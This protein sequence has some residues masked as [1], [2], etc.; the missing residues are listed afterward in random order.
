MI[1]RLLINYFYKTRLIGFKE[2]K[3]INKS[4]RLIDYKKIYHA[5]LSVSK[6]TLQCL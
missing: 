3:S 4:S 6:E 1:R 2:I 5:S